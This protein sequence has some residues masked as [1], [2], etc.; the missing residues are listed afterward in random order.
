MKQAG[1][2]P[3]IRQYH[4]FGEYHDFY[5]ILWWEPDLKEYVLEAGMTFP[6]KEAAQEYINKYM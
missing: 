2:A 5:E 1:H 4:D 6:T 3:K